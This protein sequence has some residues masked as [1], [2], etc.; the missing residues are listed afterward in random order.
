[1]TTTDP[2]F[3]RVPDGDE[4][5]G[6]EVVELARAYGVD[7]DEWQ[8]EIVRGILRESAAGWSVSQAGVCV[9][10]QN[11]KGQIL[12][13]LELAGLLLFRE[14]VL[15]T[16]HAVKTSSDGF[17][18]LWAV[19]EGHADLSRLVKRHSQQVDLEYVELTT[20][21]RAA[22]TTRSASAGRG[23]SIDRLVVDEAE[24]LPAAEV[25]ALAP[26]VFARPK[27]Q[28]VYVGTAPGPMHDAEAWATMRKAA[29]EGLNPRLAWWEWCAEYGANLDDE[30]LWR[31]VNPAVA[32]GRVA[33]QSVTD[34]RSAL[35]PDQFRAERLS[36]WIPAGAAAAVFE[37][38]DWEALLD[39][40]SIGVSDLAIGV[41]APP[42]R[43]TATVCVAGRRPDGQLHLEWYATAEG[44]RWLPEWV[45][46]RLSPQVRAVV[47][48]ARNPLAELDW[49][50]AG[51]R[52]TLA[53]SRDVA[54]AA[55]LMFD[56]VSDR[57]VRHRGQVELS[58]GVLG[59]K[60]RPMI[61]GQAFGWE[62]KAPGSSALLAASLAVWGVD[63]ANILRPR[64]RRP[65]ESGGRTVHTR[66]GPGFV[67]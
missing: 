44:V 55:G 6:K 18:R 57:L 67:M 43:D 49:R 3:A 58:R 20:G 28:S 37:A 4:T 63:A 62:R 21:G 61:G 5:T 23:L 19:I 7:L 33:L 41:D 29:H 38:S 27:A 30:D 53:G 17:R 39:L 64:R 40:D 48:D 36:M 45:S 51:V 9:A 12:T 46:A 50:A 59:A 34:D 15:H 54:A 16:A 31:R 13:A 25:G 47:V 65:G 22:F 42:S 11:G 24:D 14:Q 56:A 52:P 8:A 66:G 32:A 60:Q 1:V 10:R 26:T 35:P 2:T